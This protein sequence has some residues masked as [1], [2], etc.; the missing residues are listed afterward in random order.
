[1]TK[2]EVVARWPLLERLWDLV[3]RHLDA[4]AWGRQPRRVSRRAALE[5]FRAT[6]SLTHTSKALGVSQAPIKSIVWQALGMARRLE[7]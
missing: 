6:R 1:M 3:V 7:E 4:P 2:A 5:L